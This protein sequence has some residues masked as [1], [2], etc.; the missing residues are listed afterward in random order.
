M[1]EGNI[2]LPEFITD[3]NQ[4]FAV[5]ARSSVNAH[6]PL[7]AKDNLARILTWQETRILSKNLTLQFQKVVYQ[8]Q[9]QR[10]SYALR[11]AQVTVCV[12]AQEEL[13]ILYNSKA[14]S[15]SIYQHQAKQAQVVSTKQLDAALQP[16]RLP[17]KPAPDHPWR[18][19]FATPLSKPRSVTPP[20]AGDISILENT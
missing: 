13:T 15:Y 19:G 1:T 5:E 4:R 10:P 12:N 7:T 20:S 6:R 2:Y 3:F 8:I 9:T 14:L 16:K 17:P 11:N 18:L